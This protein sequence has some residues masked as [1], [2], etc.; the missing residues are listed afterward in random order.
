RSRCRQACHPTFASCRYDRRYRFYTCQ[1][2]VGYTG[3]GVTCRR[4]PTTTCVTPCHRPGGVCLLDPTTRRYSCRCKAGY[5]GNGVYCTPV[6]IPT[7]AVP[8]P[9]LRCQ[10]RC[11]D[12][13]DCKFNA[14]TGGRYCECAPGFSGDGRT[15]TEDSPVEIAQV[16]GCGDYCHPDAYCLITEG[17]PIGTCKCK[18]NFRG[19]GIQYCFR[20]SN[21]CLR[22]CHR[23]G[24]C[25]KVGIRYKCVCDDGYLGD[26]INY[27]SS[28]TPVEPDACNNLCVENSQCELITI[29]GNQAATCVCNE[30]YDGDG[31]STCLPT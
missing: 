6:F 26:G 20:R 12:L 31:F 25:K 10:P 14:T 19:N 11:S 22:E 4:A 17:N 7:A 27:C 23:H 8:L 30:G 3:D 13:A 15:C 1:C 18:R 29:E 28:I 24:T 16:F 5:I 21:P 2:F 9:V